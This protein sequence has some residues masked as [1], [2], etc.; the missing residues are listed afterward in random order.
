MA[1]VSFR[2]PE[3]H[4]GEFYFKAQSTTG[5][6]GA[7]LGRSSF[8]KFIKHRDT[9]IDFGCGGGF[10]LNELGPVRRIGIEI[11]PYAREHARASGVEVYAATDELPKDLM[12]D[13]II[14]SHALE[15]VENPIIELRKLARN[16]KLGGYLV[17]VVP[18]DT[19]SL[20]YKEN[21]PDFHLFSWS[22]NNIAN[23]VKCAGFTV[24]EASELK[25]RWP[26]KWDWIYMLLGIEILRLLTHVW[27]I[28]PGWRRQVRLVATRGVAG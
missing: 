3:T 9:V 15:H 26:P 19:P 20:P 2:S 28:A 25:T 8:E 23:L 1:E 17:I 16:L 22:A 10:L 7:K 24:H 27:G 18:C 4:Y 21:D 12:A 14:S 13:V 6:V 5:V 11:N